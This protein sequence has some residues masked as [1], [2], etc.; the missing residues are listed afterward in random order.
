MRGSGKTK[1]RLVKALQ[2]PETTR[3]R[4]S[5]DVDAV[6]GRADIDVVFYT[7]SAQLVLGRL[8]VERAPELL[9]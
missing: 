7:G 3:C 4:N 5:T 2:L 8:T 9:R 1:A 6:P